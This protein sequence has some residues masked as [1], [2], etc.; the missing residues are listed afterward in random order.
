M[1][2]F[3][4]CLLNVAMF[5]IPHAIGRFVNERQV[6]VHL[7]ERLSQ[8]QIRRHKKPL[9][10]GTP[11]PTRMQWSKRACSQPATVLTII[12]N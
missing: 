2:N 12:P 10:D 8:A 4:E 7:G 3:H 5:A 11:D 1:K 6:V 9:Y